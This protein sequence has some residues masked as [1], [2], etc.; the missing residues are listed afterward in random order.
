MKTHSNSFRL[1]VLWAVVSAVAFGIFGLTQPVLWVFAAVGLSPLLLRTKWIFRIAA[2]VLLLGVL[3]TIPPLVLGRTWP[4]L[5]VQ[6][7]RTNVRTVVQEGLFEYRRIKGVFPVSLAELSSDSQ[8]RLPQA[9]LAVRD[10]HEKCDLSQ[11]GYLAFLFRRWRE[12]RDARPLWAQ[13][14]GEG[15]YLFVRPDPAASENAVLL[16]TRPGLLY[17]N[18]VNVV[19]VGGTIETFERGSW[20][21]NSKV[22]TFLR[23]YSERQKARTSTES[24]K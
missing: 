21:R 1:V 6:A 10:D 20:M 7:D 14:S 16:M 2:A 15:R 24:K 8:V 18:A 11:E 23:E 19:Y 3:L 17:G 5:G 22:Q 12:N 13:F 9:C 4:N